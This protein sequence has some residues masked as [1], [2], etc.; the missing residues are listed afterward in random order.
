MVYREQS[1]L[2]KC[3]STS[4][5]LFHQD[6]IELDSAASASFLIPFIIRSLHLPR[7]WINETS[8]IYIFRH[9]DIPRNSSASHWAGGLVECCVNTRCWVWG[10]GPSLASAE[11][12]T[13]GAASCGSIIKEQ[14][15]NSSQ[16]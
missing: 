6:R 8:L 12:G 3:Q 7:L 13:A 11:G 16:G 5:T 1:L 14:R 9:Y 4:V 15:S 10:V 2:G